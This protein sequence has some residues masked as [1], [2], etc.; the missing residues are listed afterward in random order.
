MVFG[1]R[2]RSGYKSP[3]SHVN[4]GSWKFNSEFSLENRPFSKEAGSSTPLP[5]IH[6]QGFLLLIFWECVYITSFYCII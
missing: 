4:Y 1:E 2:L 6:F 3:R 5:T